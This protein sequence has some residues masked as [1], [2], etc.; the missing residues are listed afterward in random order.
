MAKS[1]NNVPAEILFAADGVRYSISER[2]GSGA[3][4]APITL[5]FEISYF[6]GA[7]TIASSTT[8]TVIAYAEV[9]RR[10]AIVIYYWNVDLTNIIAAYTQRLC[11]YGQN[12]KG[13]ATV[14]LTGIDGSDIDDDD[15]HIC[16]FG[17]SGGIDLS[18]D[19][20]LPANQHPFLLAR[21]SDGGTLHFYRSELKA[22][23][24]IYALKPGIY[25]SIYFDT[26][27]YK[28]PQRELD[29]DS[30]VISGRDELLG[31]HYYEGDSYNQYDVTAADVIFVH[32]VKDNDEVRL[33]S[34]AVQDD[35][36][37]DETHLIRWTNCMGAPEALLCTGEMRDISE[38]GQPEL[39]IQEQEYSRTNRKQQ[40][41]MATA[42]Y[43][44]MTGHLTPGRIS[45]LSDMLT[46][47]E[48]EMLIDGEW[49]PVSVTADASHAVHQR[50][51]E[52][53][54]LTIEVLEQTRYRKPN[55][56]VEP[57]D[58]PDDVLRDKNNKVITDKNSNIL[59]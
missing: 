12:I 9:V 38:A 23:D 39:Y 36:E 51:P 33:Y 18:D 4:N 8:V 46:S 29:Q 54:E 7:N 45:A 40:H 3:S 41:S 1:L 48:V 2:A 27:N 52:N 44:L 37:A 22:M 32:F 58:N 16:L 13:Y 28:A 17:T 42:K 11:K 43:S 20:E 6:W 56:A 49:V 24:L 14:Q 57:I 53:F 59:Y 34:I 55:R 10:S 21:S 15:E 30:Y 47:E 31:I 19:E 25:D 5:T 50:E 35:P 26:D